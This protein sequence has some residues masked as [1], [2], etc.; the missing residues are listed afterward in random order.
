[1]EISTD[2]PLVELQVKTEY[3]ERILYCQADVSLLAVLVKEGYRLS[4]PCGGKGNCGKCRVRIFDIVPEATLSERN[5]FSDEELAEGWRLACKTMVQAGMSVYVPEEHDFHILEITEGLQRQTKMQGGQSDGDYK[6]AID[7]GT[8]TIVFALLQGQKIVHRISMLNRQRSFGADVI[9][10]IRAS[11]EGEKDNLQNCIKADLS[12]GLQRLAEE[13]GIICNMISHI[14]IGANTTMIHL[15]LGF[16]CSGLGVYPFETVSVELQK[17]SWQELTGDE[18]CQAETVLLPGISAF[19]GGDI[20]SGLY[21]CG[22]FKKETTALLIDLGTNGEMA[23]GNKDR[24]LVTSTAAGPAFEGGNISCGTGSVEGA[25]CHVKIQ[26]SE[27]LV[28]TIGG[29]PPVGICGSGVV[30]LTSELLKAGLL[31]KTG[32]LCDD[33]LETGF[34]VAMSKNG[35]TLMFTQKD[36]R[37]LQLAKAAIRA[38]IEVLLKR[39][40]VTEEQVA[41]VYV[42]GGFGYGLDKEK[43][44]SI[45][46][47]P[48]SFRDKIQ[49]V[50]NSCLAG[51]GRYLTE[52][53][54]ANKIR[55]LREIAEEINLAT[56]SEFQTCY[57]DTM[58]FETEE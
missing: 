40:D 41:E 47:F 49:P 20:I 42:A 52:E 24:L 8:T 21:A 19:V 30:E 32:L 46:M 35:Q 13:A 58:M 5:V 27:T 34:P 37:E 53:D 1:M 28:E 15:L 12:E 10:R 48:D 18:R 11:V 33:Y 51:A 26:N 44:I 39:Y 56:D 23:L 31:D 43:A 2:V 16:D 3:E 22:F 4:S 57:I 45:G 7:I 38:G 14:A 6:A 17:M 50:G 25:V 29:K 54:G 36:I 55:H 9:S